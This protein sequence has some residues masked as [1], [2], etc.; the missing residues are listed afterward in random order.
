MDFILWNNFAKIFTF[1]Y[2]LIALLSDAIKWLNKINQHIC[3]QLL[4]IQR[5]DAKNAILKASDN[6]SNKVIFQLGFHLI[7]S[8]YWPSSFEQRYVLR[9]DIYTIQLIRNR[10]C[11]TNCLNAYEFRWKNVIHINWSFNSKQLTVF[12]WTQSNKR[13]KHTAWNIECQAC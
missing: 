7:N 9:L 4:C 11:H 6:Y 13:T 12:Q 8:E 3:M 10:N 1:W 2:D 5:C